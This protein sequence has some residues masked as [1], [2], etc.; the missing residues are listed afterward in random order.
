MNWKKHYVNDMGPDELIQKC[1]YCWKKISDYRNTVLPA[2]SPAPK[3]FPAGEIFVSE[4]NPVITQIA[5]PPSSDIWSDCRD[6]PIE[7]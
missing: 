1:I 6:K 4:G 5:E 2:G 7:Y 3:G